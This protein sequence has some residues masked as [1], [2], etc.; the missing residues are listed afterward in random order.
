MDERLAETSVIRDI[1][2]GRERYVTGSVCCSKLRY[3]HAS[4]GNML[5]VEC[6]FY[7]TSDENILNHGATYG[8]GREE[9]W[10]C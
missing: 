8:F 9:R 4:F 2:N 5:W 3:K 6:G 1:L 10:I 7:F